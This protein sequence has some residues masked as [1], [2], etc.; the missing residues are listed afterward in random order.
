MTLMSVTDKQRRLGLQ[1]GL[2][3][4]SSSS[5]RGQLMMTADRNDLVIDGRE[6][7]DLLPLWFNSLTRSPSASNFQ[8]PSISYYCVLPSG[9]LPINIRICRLFAGFTQ[10]VTFQGLNV[11]CLLVCCYKI[12]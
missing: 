11:E 2:A 7:L 3:S 12:Y 4:S 9:L 1:P 10:H 6:R 8:M 5:S